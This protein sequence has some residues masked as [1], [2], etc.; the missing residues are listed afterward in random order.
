MAPAALPFDLRLAVGVA[1][2]EALAAALVRDL[3][4]RGRG[5]PQALVGAA[6]APVALPH[7]VGDRAPAV[8][9]GALPLHQRQAVDVGFGQATSA[10]PGGIALDLFERQLAHRYDSLG[11]RCLQ[12]RF[13]CR[14]AA[15]KRG[16]GLLCAIHLPGNACRLSAKGGSSGA[17]A[18]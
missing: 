3:M 7:G 12:C 8:A 11:L 16:A 14:S 6:L 10:E 5:Q 4:H 15:V 13:G 17:L 18:R 9:G 2:G 1:L